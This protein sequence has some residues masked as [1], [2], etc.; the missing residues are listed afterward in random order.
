MRRG[1]ERTKRCP[2]ISDDGG[3]VRLGDS[4]IGIRRSVADPPVR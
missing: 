1:I 2:G 4:C 3:E